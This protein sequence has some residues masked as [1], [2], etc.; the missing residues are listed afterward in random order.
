MIY[1]NTYPVMYLF[2]YRGAGLS[3]PSIHCHTATTWTGCAE[4]LINTTVPLSPE[5]SLKIIHAMSNQNIA[6]DLQYQIQF[7][8]N[9]SQ[10]ISQQTS[11]Y[12]YGLSQGT[13]IIEYY[14]SIQSINSQLQ[15]IDGVI[16]DG[17]MSIKDSDAAR[18]Q[19]KTHNDRFYMYISK[20]QQDTQCLKAF[21]TVTGTDQDLLSVTLR[22]QML[23]LTN[24]TNPLCTYN[25][26]LKDWQ[27][28][29]Q[30]AS[31]G[32]KNVA[33]RPVAIILIARL[34]RCS[35]DDQQILSRAIPIMIFL[36]QQASSG[37][38]I[39]PPDNYQNDGSVLSITTIWSDFIGLTLN[40][41][42]KTNSE[43]YND[44]CINNS[45]VNELYLAPTGT[46]PI[47]NETK[48]SKYNYTLPSTFKDVLYPKNPRYWGQFQV[49]P[50]IFRS[51]QNGALLF[52]GDLDYNSPLT[53]AQQVQ[54]SFNMQE[55]STKLVVMKGLT[56]VTSIQS[57]TKIGGFEMPSCTEQIIV[58][59]LYQQELNLTL[60]KLNDTCNS[61]D[62][63]IGI[64]WFYKNP[65]VNQTL[66]SVFGNSTYNYWGINTSN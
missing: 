3:K 60:S 63:L 45:V 37:H 5:Q 55:I 1:P 30:I 28:F 56:H 40:D 22:L 47:C 12:I 51:R 23:F 21:N 7:T 57:Y 25:N 6:Q 29:I 9:Q 54:T 18:N 19:I 50:R 35:L 10:P 8:I 14:L 42:I 48:L 11:T 36:V 38:L 59:F 4:E 34:Y 66:H 32:I 65:T 13:G 49:N 33:V 17:I 31:E 27:L 58:Q 39:D 41:S 46:L 2:Q 26:G 44:L 53:T 52:N 16:L 61:I 20:C 24:K 15:I 43:F 62:T 64:D